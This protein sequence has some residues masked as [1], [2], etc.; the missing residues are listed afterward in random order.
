MEHELATKMQ[1]LGAA[2]V[3]GLLFTVPYVLIKADFGAFVS[4]L[5]GIFI[6]ALTGVQFWM[7]AKRGQSIGKSVLKIRITRV[8]GE[9]NGGFFTNVFKR[10]IVSGLLNLVPLYWVIDSLLI[11]RQDRRCIHDLIAGTHV[12]KGEPDD[13]MISTEAPAV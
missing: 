7:L 4:A 10:T 5:G 11:F 1:R 13:A 3:D 2:V 8:N 6:L 9:D 12:V